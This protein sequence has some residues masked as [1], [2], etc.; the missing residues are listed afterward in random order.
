MPTFRVH[1][2]KEALRPHFRSAPHTAGTTIVKPKDYEPAESIEATSVYAAWETL[3]GSERPL[4][5]GDIL[6]AEGSQLRI[7]KYI[8]FEEAQWFVPEPVP[9]SAN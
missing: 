6:E 7:C 5:V 8:G 3:R 9:V 4:E 2:L 1:R